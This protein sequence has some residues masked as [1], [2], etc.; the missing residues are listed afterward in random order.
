MEPG[1]LSIIVL[2]LALAFVALASAAEYALAGLNRGRIRHLAEEGDK[3][4]IR[5][6][7]IMSNPSQFLL[8]FASVKT[9]GALLAGISITSMWSYFL[10]PLQFGLVALGT[11]IVLVSI[12]VLARSSVQQHAERR[13]IALFARSLRHCANIPSAHCIVADGRYSIQ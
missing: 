5:L 3:N 10:N 12:K 8:T 4:A 2:F 13:R 11:W 6:E 1:P 7:S 9:L